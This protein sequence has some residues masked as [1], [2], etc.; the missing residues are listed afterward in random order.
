MINFLYIFLY[1]QFMV[2]YGYYFYIFTVLFCRMEEDEESYGKKKRL[3]F[4]MNTFKGDEKMKKVVL[5]LLL[6]MVGIFVLTACNSEETTS[7]KNGVKETSLSPL[8]KPVN[9]KIGYPT[10]GVSQLPLWVAKDTGIFKKYGVNA[11][12]VYISGSPRVQETLNAGGIDVGISGI[13]SA[14]SAKAAGIDSVTFTALANKIA[15]YIY[16]SKDIDTSNIKEEIKGKTIIAGNEG[17]LYDL[18]AQS[19]V[20]ELGLEPKKDVKFLYMGGEGDRTAA[21][22]KGDGDFYLVAP[23]TS[24]KMDDMGYPKIHDFSEKD[25]LIPGLV[26]KKDYYNENQEL[27]KVLAGSLI[28]ANAYIKNNKEETLKI[29]SKWTGMDDAEL[30][31][32]TYETNLKTIPEKP[33]S[34]DETVQFYLDH[35]DNAEVKAMKPA[36]LVDNSIIKKLDDSGFIDEVFN[37]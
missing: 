15:V 34:T 12:L 2:H 11:E 1:Y 10:Q 18:L 29:I 21:F 17:S 24:F 26:M 35:S 33:Y 13:E 28:E 3:T 19:Y 9:I 5:A 6:A 32:K 37:Q 30:V 27:A 25:V 16:A 23:P 7:G 31:K 22:M 36:D 4:Y 14:G 8:S 20:R